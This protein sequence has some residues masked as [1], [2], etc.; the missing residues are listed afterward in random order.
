MGVRVG[1]IAS[2]NTTS[3]VQVNSVAVDSAWWWGSN[4]I[5]APVTAREAFGDYGRCGN[6]VGKAFVA[7]EMRSCGRGQEPCWMCGRRGGRRGGDGGIGECRAAAAAEG[8][9]GEEVEGEGLRGLTWHE[10]IGR[11][12]YRLK[13]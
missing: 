5:C 3:R 1:E 11:R 12:V 8:Y 9:A 6:E 4:Q 7:A 10:A 13:L 2:P